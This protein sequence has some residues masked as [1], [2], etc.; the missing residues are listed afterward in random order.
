MAEHGFS[1]DAWLDALSERQ[2]LDVMGDLAGGIAHQLNNALSV[3]NGYEELLLETLDTG[4]PGSGTPGSGTPGSGTPGS[5]T[6]GS[7]QA[8]LG[9][10]RAEL[11]AKALTVHTWTGTALSVARRLHALAAHLRLDTGPVEV[12]LLVE[13]AVELCRFRCERDSILLICDLHEDLPKVSACHGELLQVLINLVHNA[14][15][16]IGRNDDAGGTIRVT[17]GVGAR[18]IQIA[19]DDDGPG[20]PAD[21]LDRIFGIGVSA[22]MGDGSG[23]GLPVSR[24]I[25]QRLGGALSTRADEGGRFLIDLPSLQ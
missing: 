18:G 13:E 6:P 16:A 17:T 10:D 25:V 12:N 14:R 22:K 21:D 5:G 2:R 8:P 15:E 11:L 23:L 7:G 20:V 24:R 1:E 9:D 3:V 19:V 4:T